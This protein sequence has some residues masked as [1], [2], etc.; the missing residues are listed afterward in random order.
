MHQS[1]V[2][3]LYGIRDVT[4]SKKLGGTMGWVQWSEPVQ[5]GDVGGGGA[6]SPPHP[7]KFFLKFELFLGAL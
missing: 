6:V 4:G 1:E 3:I 2:H 7:P 5:L